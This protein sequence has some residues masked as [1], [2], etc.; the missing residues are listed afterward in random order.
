MRRVEC[1]ERSRGRKKSLIT[2]QNLNVLLESWTLSCPQFSRSCVGGSSV[3]SFPADFSGE[4]NAVD[5]KE[6]TNENIFFLAEVS[7]RPKEDSTDLRFESR[8]ESGNLGK[9]VKITD[10]YY[11]LYLRRDLYT[12]RHTQ[13]YYFRVSNTRSRITYRY[14]IEQASVERRHST[15]DIK[16]SPDLKKGKGLNIIRIASFASICILFF[17]SIVRHR[18]KRDEEN[19]ETLSTGGPKFFSFSFKSNARRVSKIDLVL[20]KTNIY[21]IKMVLLSTWDCQ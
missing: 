5:N 3:L 9:V 7:T 12:Q 13:W 18:L 17:S 1:I 10:T 8:F 11:Q 4:S 15:I 6:A 21:Q 20:I 19:V 16:L 14:A 2:R